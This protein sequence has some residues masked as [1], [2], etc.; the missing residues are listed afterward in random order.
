MTPVPRKRNTSCKEAPF[1]ERQKALLCGGDYWSSF[2]FPFLERALYIKGFHPQILLFQID[3]VAHLWH[4]GIMAA[5]KGVLLC[6]IS[7][8]QLSNA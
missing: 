5:E 3:F 6:S 2:I 1:V 7:I 8:P 4:N